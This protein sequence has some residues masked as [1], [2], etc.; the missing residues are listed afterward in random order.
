MLLFS[1]VLP[2]VS[3]VLVIWTHQE[4]E[5]AALP[6]GAQLATKFSTHQAIQPN[7]LC[8]C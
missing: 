2:L 6:H 4:L 7:K 1:G 3:Q 8:I 5:N